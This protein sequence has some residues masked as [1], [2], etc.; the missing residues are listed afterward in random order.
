MPT[1]DDLTVSLTIKDN[2]N[3]D[4][5][6]KNI[7]ALMKT[8]V[9]SG[10]G[11]AGIS[12][13]GDLEK[14]TNKVYSKLDYLEQYILPVSLGTKQEDITIAG[15]TVLKLIEDFDL[16]GKIRELWQGGTPAAIAGFMKTY[17]LA[18]E[19]E[20]PGLLEDLFEVSRITISSRRKELLKVIK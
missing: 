1:V 3:L 14:I 8:G 19:E 9:V 17:Q 11:G 7:D 20:I 12:K 6:R 5:L 15:A 18:S 2:S 10:T 4:K 16:K 13:M